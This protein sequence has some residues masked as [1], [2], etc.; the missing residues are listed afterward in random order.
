M[1]TTKTELEKMYIEEDLSGPQIAERLNVHVCTIYRKLKHFGIE[2]EPKSHNLVGR[3][4]GKW[5]V[6]SETVN[7]LCKARCKCGYEK[8]LQPHSLLKGR[9]KQCYNCRPN[10]QNGADNHRW[11]GHGEI[12][13]YLWEH[14][15]KRSATRRK[16]P[17]DITI[18]TAWSQFLKQERQCALTGLP[19][20][21]G[22][23]A[24]AHKTK[25]ASLDRID[26]RH[27]Y[28]DGNVQWVHKIVNRMK[29]DMD[30]KEFVQFCRLIVSQ[31]DR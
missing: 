24:R 25:T 20:E 28:I 11:K 13:A 1:E 14:H 26:S 17:F 10:L 5:T 2:K 4:F 29:S 8:E 6:I 3:T 12:S 15:I 9:T 31:A 22:P 21:F 7:G 27:G 30:E 23:T 19:I 16:I 18:E